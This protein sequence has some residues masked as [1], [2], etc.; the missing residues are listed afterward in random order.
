MSKLTSTSVVER[1]V[2]IPF[3]DGTIAATRYDPVAYDTPLPV[4]LMTIPYRKDDNITYGAYDPLIRYLAKHG[5][6]VV[7]SDLYGTGASSGFLEKPHAFQENEATTVVEWMAD[8]EWSTGHVG[9][10]GK[11]YG[12]RTC[13]N[14]AAE[15][16]ESLK[17]IV[18][19]T[20]SYSSYDDSKYQGGTINFYKQIG[21]W[22]PMMQTLAAMPP[23]RRDREGR[24]ASVWHEH[25]DGLD[26]TEPWLFQLLEHDHKDEY[27]KDIDPDIERIDVPVFAISG[28]RDFYPHAPLEWLPELDVPSRI[29]MGPWRHTVP[30]RGREVAINGREQILEWFDYFLKDRDNGALDHPY[31]EYWTECSGGGNIDGGVWRAGESWPTVEDATETLSFA[32]SPDGLVHD[33]E[34]R[35]GIVETEYQFDQTVGIDSIDYLAPPSDT[36]ADDARSLVFETDQLSA[37]VEYTGTGRAHIRVTPTVEDH[38]LAVRLVDVGPHG[39]ASLVSY[40]RIQASQRA[41]Y[42]DPESLTPREEYGI[43]LMLKPKSHVFERGH[44]IRVAISAA[45]FPLVLAPR[46]QGS[47]TVTSEPGHPS[48]IEFPGQVHGEEVIFDDSI[49]QPKPDDD[50][51]AVSSDFATVHDSSWETSRSHRSNGAVFTTTVD[52]TLELPHGATMHW[53]REVEAR[54]QHDEPLTSIAR[55]DADIR[56]EYTDE[57]VRIKASSRAGH[58]TAAITERVWV[59]NQL[60]YD[61]TWRWAREGDK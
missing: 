48:L 18:P 27:W 42:E 56:I 32:L 49:E 60:T 26:R 12:G 28:W 57:T 30:H 11:S 19:I 43:T 54:V 3:E 46:Y 47:F 61:K 50:V 34:F 1:D 25:L 4:L 16:P 21:D 53:E 44:R 23:S 5:Y 35:S 10:F 38:L 36:S 7:V 51:V 9:M 59:D 37:P 24:W 33:S 15:R 31:I 17:A 55:S 14:A 6:N 2:S 41:S 20:A 8:Q 45:Y 39:D 22:T 40:G 52:K 29:L 13:L 58:D